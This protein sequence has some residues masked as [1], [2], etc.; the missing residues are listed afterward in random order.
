MV[1]DI[2]LAAILSV[3]FLSAAVM[4]FL[5]LVL[6]RAAAGLRQLFELRLLLSF[7]YVSALLVFTAY[8]S[9]SQP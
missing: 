9:S 2:W 3:P 7:F 5:Y 8:F 1:K 6:F 4:F